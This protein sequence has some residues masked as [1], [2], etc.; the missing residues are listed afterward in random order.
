MTTLEILHW[1]DVHGRWHGLARLSARA[2]AIRAEAD[3]PV[4]LLDGGDVEEGSVRL[5]GLSK[6]V[7]GWRLLGAAGVDAAVVGNGGLLRYGPELLPDYA[8]ALQSPPLVCDLDLDGQAPPGSARS[9]IVTADELRVGVIGAT[10]YYPQYDDFGLAERGRVTAVRGEADLL[11]RSGADVVVLLSHCGY[12]ADMA[13]SWSLRGRVDLVVGGHSHDVLEDADTSKGVPIV[14][15]GCN[16]E[17]LGRVRLSVGSN[18][19]HL[20]DVRHEVVSDEWPPDPAVVD[21]LAACERD[22]E[23]WLDEPVTELEAPVSWH[24]LRDSGIAG[25]MT[26][27]LL[28]RYPGDVG[29]LLAGHCTGGLPAGTVTRADVW[30]ATSSPGNAATATLSGAALRAMVLRG[31]SE[32]HATTSARTFRG[33]PYGELHLVGA[34]VSDGELYV[35]DAPVDDARSYRVTGSDLE[36]KTYGHLVETEAEDLVLH[37]P[38]IL[39][40]LLEEYLKEH[41]AGRQP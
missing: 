13:L 11:R 12:H 39:P 7:A 27:A 3:H 20:V 2:R 36:L 18:G 21:E 17:R 29:V 23:A 19:V 26:K 6:G 16:G 37:T 22:L 31:V 15:A 35:G 38:A 32:E 30:A 33:R 9:R 8:A 10:D 4:L 34:R 14:Q 41:G 24:E 28:S 25:L 5:S 1:N 40:E